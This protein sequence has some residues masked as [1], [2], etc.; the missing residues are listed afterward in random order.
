MSLPIFSLVLIS[1]GVLAAL[2][3][4]IMLLVAAF[5]ESALW[6][7]IVLFAPLGNL[8]YTCVHWTEAKAGFLLSVAGT[9]VC[10]G[11]IFTLPDARN[12]LLQASQTQLAGRLSPQ[13]AAKQ[14]TVADLSTQIAEKRK[15]VEDL[16]GAFASYGQELPTQFKELEKRR[17][18]LKTGD[19]VA[20]AKFNEDAAAY[21]AK[22]KRH[23]EIQQEIAG[24]QSALDQLIDAR[25]RAAAGARPG[26]GKQV[27]MYT[28]S[29]CPAC[30]MAK[31][32]MAQKGIPY[33]E[34][35]VE[36]SRDGMQAFQKL[37]G[38]GV[39]LIIVGDK[40]MEGFNSQ[41]LERML[42]S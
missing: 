30:K 40:K 21:Q 10:I 6:G 16:Q 1:L 15:L 4:G 13:I 23:R 27:V 3:G 39:P 2:I 18:A 9:L 28:T 22:N 24:A 11:A 19:D 38:R 29:H 35:D 5:R 31:Q 25:S 36:S 17:T 34:I 14:P 12:A 26:G 7:F 33:Q 41:E 37:G 8:I 42:S 20:I 32:Y